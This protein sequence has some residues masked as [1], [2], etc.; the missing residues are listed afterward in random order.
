MADKLPQRAAQLHVGARDLVDAAEGGRGEGRHGRAGQGGWSTRQGVRQRAR[1]R[2]SHPGCPA[3]QGLGLRTLHRIPFLRSPPP[4]MH[5]C[6]L[7]ASPLP[8]GGQVLARLA[9]HQFG[10]HLAALALH[11]RSGRGRAAARLRGAR[12]SSASRQAGRRASGLSVAQGRPSAVAL[13]PRQPPRSARVACAACA[14]PS[15]PRGP[16]RFRLP[17]TPRPEAWPAW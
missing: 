14:R 4:Y 10:L 3:S 6:L 5:P 2:A 13:G 9:G 16:S 17:G 15:A 11:R 1:T 8:D 7:P 12:A